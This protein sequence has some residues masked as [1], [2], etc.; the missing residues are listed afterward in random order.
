MLI[1]FSY[2]G[3]ALQQWESGVMLREK[4]G[5][6]VNSSNHIMASDLN[7]QLRSLDLR[8][9]LSFGNLYLYF[10]FKMNLKHMSNRTL[11]FSFTL[12]YPPFISCLSEWH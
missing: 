10:F 8:I 6:S 3:L 7:L 1:T 12:E 11:L 2:Y 9:S 5:V 4:I